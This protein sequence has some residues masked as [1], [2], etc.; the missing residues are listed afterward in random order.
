MNNVQYPLYKYL[1]AYI[2]I[3]IPTIYNNGL[4]Y[5]EVASKLL[6]Q[7]NV[8]KTN[9]DIT[10]EDY[11]LISEYVVMEIN[12]IKTLM[13]N[14]KNNIITEWNNY[15]NNKDELKDN[16]I[17]ELSNK[18]E[19]FITEITTIS[20]NFIT[21]IHN[22][23]NNYASNLT[24]ISDTATES[25]ENKLQEY[26]NT[27]QSSFNNLDSTLT[28]TL[29]NLYSSYQNLEDSVISFRSG[30]QTLMNEKTT[31]YHN[32]IHQ[33]DS[34]IN[35]LPNEIVN[36]TDMTSDIIKWAFNNPD[37][38]PKNSLFI[39]IN[40]MSDTE[41]I[42]LKEKEYWY[43]TSNNTLYYKINNELTIVPLSN[44]FIYLFEH[45]IFF[46]MDAR[47]NSIRITIPNTFFTNLNNILS[48]HDKQLILYNYSTKDLAVVN[49]ETQDFQVY[50]NIDIRFYN[51]RTGNYTDTLLYYDNKYYFSIYNETDDTFKNYYATSIQNLINKNW[52]E[53]ID[54]ENG[55]PHYLQNFHSGYRYNDAGL[56][57]TRNYNEE[58]QSG[59]FWAN[60]QKSNGLPFK[61]TFNKT[62]K[63]VLTVNDNNQWVYFDSS[64]IGYN[65][66]NVQPDG[67]GTD[68]ICYK[69]YIL[70]GK[71][72]ATDNTAFT[73]NQTFKYQDNDIGDRY[74]VSD[75]Y[76]YKYLESSKILRRVNLN[77]LVVRDFEVNTFDFVDMIEDYPVSI[78]A[79]GNDSV[80]Y[81]LDLEQSPLKLTEVLYEVKTNA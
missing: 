61:G 64:G 63:A 72:F 68:I 36:A 54:T 45:R 31:F 7:L 32:E 73:T 42:E 76:Y 51:E 40:Y 11:T 48:Y 2:N 78:G 15:D 77:S 30:W 13:N 14:F 3:C 25:F 16:T 75:T 20:D 22:T 17:N 56:P 46:V 65:E 52:T 1:S 55:Y 53:I 21:E 71:G 66:T 23:F 34:D 81:L 19:Q 58:Q 69:G 24:N 80:V 70:N 50:K 47:D 67:Y 79:V 33:Y 4:S 59:F 38:F 57:C 60:T 74:Y 44:N 6:E 9:Q 35:N 43:N 5:Y 27:I 28:S 18:T 26:R 41:P 12:S 29:D 8:L 37:K 62:L 49:I 10:S 39:K